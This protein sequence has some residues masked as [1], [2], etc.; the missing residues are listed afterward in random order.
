M[1]DNEHTYEARDDVR[2]VRS[3]G[4]IQTWQYVRH[5]TVS[6]IDRV[7]VSWFSPD[8]DDR[9]YKCPH[10]GM[11]DHWQEGGMSTTTE[12]WVQWRDSQNTGD[13]VESVEADAERMPF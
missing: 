2:V 3:N 4:E 5:I 8:H 7:L 11:F 10:V 1:S 12:Q 6:G 9:L 13:V